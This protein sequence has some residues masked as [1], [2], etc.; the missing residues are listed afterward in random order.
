MNDLSLVLQG[1]QKD[2]HASVNSVFQEL[3]KDISDAFGTPAR[4]SDHH[5]LPMQDQ[6]K[7]EQSPNVLGR[8]SNSPASYGNLLGQESPFPNGSK[9]F[10]EES[11]DGSN[12]FKDGSSNGL[13]GLKEGSFNSTKGFTDGVKPSSKEHLSKPPS[14]LPKALS[15]LPKKT[16][17]RSGGST[18]T[19]TIKAHGTTAERVA[20]A[21]D[22]CRAKK[23]K[24]DGQNPCSLCL[25][26]GL[27]C[28]VSD[29]LSR[30]AYPKGYTE[31]LEERVRQLEAENKRL[32]GLLDARDELNELEEQAHLTLTNLDLHNELEDKEEAHEDGCPCGCS[33]PHAV[34]ERP[35]SIAGPMYDN[36]MAGVV[37]IANSINLSDD[38][39]DADDVSSIVSEGATPQTYAGSFG[40]RS[41]SPA[42]GAFAAATA[43]AQMQ[44]NKAFRQQ[45]EILENEALKP[46]QLTAL[47]AISI[48]RSTEETLFIPTL[49]AKICQVYGYNSRP[50]I[51]TANALASLKEKQQQQQLP[52]QADLPQQ[53]VEQAALISVDLAD[54]TEFAR[55][56]VLPESR[57]DMDH[58]ITVYFQ[59]WRN[60]LPILDKNAFLKSYVR[61]TEKRQVAQNGGLVPGDFVTGDLG[62]DF[63]GLPHGE[64]VEK[65]GAMMV[66]VVSLGLLSCRAQYL[67][68]GAPYVGLLAYYDHL[69]HEFIKPSCVVTSQCSIQLLQVLA[70][71]LQY[72]LVTGDTSTCYELR[73]R[74]V[75]MAQ[76]LRLHRCPAAVLG[77]SGIGTN[78]NVQNYMQ[79]E[80]RI[81]FWCIYCLDI[82][83]SLNLGVPRLLKEFEIECAM[84][85]LGKND[86]EDAE[87]EN[88]LIVNNTRL[89]I[90]GKVTKLALSFMLYCKVLGSILDGIFSSDHAGDAHD[91]SL[92]MDRQLELWRRDLPTD[93][94]FDTAVTGTDAWRAC[95]RPQLTLIFL[96]Y[97]AKILIYMPVVSKYGNHHDVGLSKKEQLMRTAQL[98]LLIV[99]SVSSIQQAL[100]QILELLK[101]LVQHNSAFLLPVPLNIVREHARLALLVAKGSLDYVKGGTLFQSLKLLLLDVISFLSAESVYE[102]PGALNKTSAKLLELAI[103]SILG[104]NISKPLKKRPQPAPRPIVSRDDG[105]LKQT[106]T[107]RLA[108]DPVS[109]SSLLLQNDDPLDSILQFDPFEIKLNRDNFANEFAADGSLGLVPFLDSAEKDWGG[110]DDFGWV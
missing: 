48:P 77:L 8:R 83:L 92:Q 14:N 21:C 80:R 34:H 2:Y 74:V 105:L 107:S 23:T 109:R 91:R 28:I 35:V 30:R 106:P 67:R 65:V 61:W 55:R 86:D 29:K 42:P 54:P 6:V 108:S 24:C 44:K 76:Q 11:F 3:G 78:V 26:V 4:A 18:N 32:A 52:Q 10:K 40:G 84:P 66:L 46:Q 71:A 53:A 22:R 99:S 95:S 15:N 39:L 90:V 96:Y 36:A 89:S 62:G 85:F 75:T 49:L 5:G 94:K 103:L 19:K 56:L 98:K 101:C 41:I 102:I 69:I 38:E 70:L 79:G 97:H 100:I 63:A 27:E 60:T 16:K 58:L 64:A 51:I 50:A 12:G 1:N 33:N 37:S 31:T 57:I 68:P 73:G 110:S 59:D 45:Q 93:L 7:L 72:C 82:Y 43:I 20:Q 104:I 47:V 87:N 17:L 9:G 88:I 25:A 13:K 81:L